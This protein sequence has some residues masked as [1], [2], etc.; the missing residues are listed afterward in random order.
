MESSQ[1]K[2]CVKVLK[3]LNESGVLRHIVLIG[4]WCIPLY[5]EYFRG[6]EYRTSITTRDVDFF[7]PLP[8][9]IKNRVD[10]E[11]VLKGLGFVIG[12]RGPEGYISFNHPELILEFLVADRGAGSDKPYKLDQL[13]VNAQPLRFLNLLTR[14]LISVKVGDIRISLPHPALF[15]LHKIIVSEKRSRKEK[16]FKDLDSAVRIMTALIDK[17]EANKLKF[18]FDGF[19]PKLRKTIV[20]TLKSNGQLDLAEVL[21]G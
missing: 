3:R 14:K 7:V 13:G 12:F 19:T 11:T 18:F 21:Y 6:S 1:Y 5:R 4:S 16:S 8:L 20:N 9:G 15:A 17:G 10:I 2:L